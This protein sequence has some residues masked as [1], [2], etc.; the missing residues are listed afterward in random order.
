MSFLSTILQGA[1]KYFVGLGEAL[2]GSQAAKNLEAS[3]V[4]FVKDDIGAVAVDAVNY[5]STL[6]D[7][8]DDGKRAAAVAKLKSDLSTA[9]HD[10]TTIA[11]S[12]FNLFI[13]MAYTYVKGTVAGL[14]APTIAAK[15]PATPA[16]EA[17]DKA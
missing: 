11:E 10:I 9:G 17:A 5:A 16:A 4:G 2:I 7:T 12:T 3:I 15:V 14:V 1:E 6:P 13:E 8:T